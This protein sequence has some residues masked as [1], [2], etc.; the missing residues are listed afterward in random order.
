MKRVYCGRKQV[1]GYKSH[2]GF[3]IILTLKVSSFVLQA[4]FTFFVSCR[5]GYMKQPGR[6]S[7]AQSR[8][9]A[10]GCSRSK[11]VSQQERTID[12]LVGQKANK[13]TRPVWLASPQD[14]YRST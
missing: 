9:C 3:T 8:N 14:C 4:F 7:L 5:I 2:W 11:S 6:I 13:N 10:H 12:S 1:H